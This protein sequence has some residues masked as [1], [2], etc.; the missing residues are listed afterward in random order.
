MVLQEL[1]IRINRHEFQNFL[2]YRLGCWI[3]K[4]IKYPAQNAASGR[5]LLST[6]NKEHSSLP[7][8][9][10]TRAF[11]K[12]FYPK[13]QVK[14]RIS[15]HS[16]D[17]CHVLKKNQLFELI[18][19]PADRVSDCVTTSTQWKKFQAK[20]KMPHKGGSKSPWLKLRPRTTISQDVQTWFSV[21]LAF[22]KF[23]SKIKEN[24]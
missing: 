2:F 11:I 13:C 12:E 10:S 15:L 16:Q 18:F 7:N 20:S 21:Q 22:A 9:N 19:L 8:M 5:I 23:L 24:F 4:L 1:D 14:F 3:L 17:F 6:G